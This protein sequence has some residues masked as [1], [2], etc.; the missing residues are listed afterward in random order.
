MSPLKQRPDKAALGPLKQRPDKAA[1]GPLK[2][3]P[4]KVAP[5][6]STKRMGGSGMVDFGSLRKFPL[7]SPLSS[8]F[9]IRDT[10][11]DP[12]VG[13]EEERPQ[14]RP[15]HYWGTLCSPVPE[16]LR[17]TERVPRWGDHSPVGP[18]PRGREATGPPVTED[19]QASGPVGGGRDLI[20]EGERKRG[21]QK[22]R[23]VP[24]LVDVPGIVHSDTTQD[25]VRP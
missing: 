1:L 12:D 11:H 24:S 7:P 14:T 8:S 20:T 25:A 10:V 16:C 17:R 3:R 15:L 19:Y 21:S 22:P 9:G 4:D 23:G 18:A 2:Q 5:R 6:P 13:G